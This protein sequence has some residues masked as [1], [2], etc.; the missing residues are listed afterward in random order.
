ML[1]RQAPL[2][3]EFGAYWLSKLSSALGMGTGGWREQP[4]L[5]NMAVGAFTMSSFRGRIGC[6]DHRQGPGERWGL[7][8]AECCDC[9]Q[10]RML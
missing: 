10:A 9:S 6:P 5:S 7:R 1:V 8:G 2:E 4:M 3:H